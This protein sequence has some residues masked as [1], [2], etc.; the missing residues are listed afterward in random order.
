MPQL[1]GPDLRLHLFGCGDI[2]RDARNAIGLSLGVL[3]REA[4]IPDPTDL[5][6]RGDDR[7][8]P[9]IGEV[10]LTGS[11]GGNAFPVLRMDVIEPE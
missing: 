11:C 3:D 4:S 8:F 10:F 5:S 9:V 7:I 1:T 2:D 6:A